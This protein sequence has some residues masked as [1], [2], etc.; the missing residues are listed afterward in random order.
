MFP[1]RLAWAVVA[2]LNVFS[3]LFAK[4]PLISAGGPKRPG[5]TGRQLFLYGR[6]IEAEQAKKNAKT[7]AGRVKVPDDWYLVKS[8]PNGMEQILATGVGDY[9]LLPAGSGVVVTDGSAVK[10][11]SGDE[12]PRVLAKARM[13]E[14]VGAV[15]RSLHDETG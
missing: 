8:W 2:F 15:R 12:P 3:L 13:I 6:L 10:V 4:K 11:I 14:R 9:A 1:I 7:E 5:P